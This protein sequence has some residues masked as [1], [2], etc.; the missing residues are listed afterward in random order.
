MII[1]KISIESIIIIMRVIMTMIIIIMMLIAITMMLC[2]IITFSL[3]T[4]KD[5]AG[6]STQPYFLFLSTDRK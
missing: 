4:N 2:Q 6:S 3:N 1:I 5:S